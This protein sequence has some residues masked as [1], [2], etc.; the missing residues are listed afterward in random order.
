MNATTVFRSR[1]MSPAE[2]HRA[3]CTTQGAATG[4]HWR[5][6]MKARILLT[7]AVLLTVTGLFLPKSYAQAKPDLIITDA[8][9]TAQKRGDT[10]YQLTVTITVANY[11][12]GTT[13]SDSQ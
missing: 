3:E 13:A 1:S 9:M 10:V 8:Q 12:H 6:T 11:C 5:K 7:L 4:T 2:S